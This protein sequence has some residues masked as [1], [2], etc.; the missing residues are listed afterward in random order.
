VPDSVSFAQVD[1]PTGLRAVAGG[2]A[3][4]EVFVKG[5]EPKEYAPEPEV[6]T[7]SPPAA[8]DAVGDGVPENA[9]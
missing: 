7:A 8:E 5:S 3:E 4:L 1:R 9:D 2:D 6:E